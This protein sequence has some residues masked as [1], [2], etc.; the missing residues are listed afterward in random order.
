MVC[1]NPFHLACPSPHCKSHGGPCAA[2]CTH[3]NTVC[4]LLGSISEPPV[5]KPMSRF[6]YRQDTTELWAAPRT[7]TEPRTQACTTHHTLS[8]CP[9]GPG[10]RQEVVR[11]RAA[12]APWEAPRLAGQQSR[13]EP[14]VRCWHGHIQV[15]GFQPACGR[16]PAGKGQRVLLPWSLNQH[17]VSCWRPFS[18]VRHLQRGMGL[19]H[20]G[21]LAG[22]GAHS[23]ICQH[24]RYRDQMGVSLSTSWRQQG[25]QPRFTPLLSA[26]RQVAGGGRHTFNCPPALR[27]T[28]FLQLGE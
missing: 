12:P 2:V 18:E 15:T 25:V 7:R 13:E 17:F 27:N 11:P 14:G 28:S 8:C 20:R 3:A 24:T 22:T 23:T 4:Y 10:G 21:G 1:P 9:G 26:L 19:I 6:T 16:A 5:A